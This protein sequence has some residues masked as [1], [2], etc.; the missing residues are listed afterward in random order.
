MVVRPRCEISTR[1]ILPT[2]RGL[3]ARILVEEYGFSQS[4]AAEILGITQAAVSYYISSKRGQKWVKKLEK[5]KKA[6]KIIDLTAR[7]I[8][9]AKNPKKVSIDLCSICLAI[10]AQEA[11]SY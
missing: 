3:I 8:A 4:H 10:S 2:V 6:K 5:N 1:Y 9:K 11:I 7:R